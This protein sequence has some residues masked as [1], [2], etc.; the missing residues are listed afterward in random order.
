M[1]A[2]RSYGD[3]AYKVHWRLNFAGEGQPQERAN[4]MH[5]MMYK[6]SMMLLSKYLNED[7]RSP[8]PEISDMGVTCDYPSAVVRLKQGHTYQKLVYTH[9]EVHSVRLSLS[10]DETTLLV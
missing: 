4:F 2:L 7:L 9:I 6:T 10:S 3:R 8:P 1:Y 5:I